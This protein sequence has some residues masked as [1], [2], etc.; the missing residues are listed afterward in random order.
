MVETTLSNTQLT[1]IITVF[2]MFVVLN[3]LEENLMFKEALPRGS[4]PSTDPKNTMAAATHDED[5]NDSDDE[6][7]LI[8][9]ISLEFNPWTVVKPGEVIGQSLD[10]VFATF[11][12]FTAIV[13]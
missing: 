3:K 7:G 12:L 8:G 5:D 1:K 9:M 4:A 10:F 6:T 13:F 2:P 11:K